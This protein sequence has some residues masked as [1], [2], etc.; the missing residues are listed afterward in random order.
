MM[1]S[2]SLRVN[3]QVRAITTGGGQGSWSR[4]QVKGQVAGEVGGR[5][6]EQVKG[7]RNGRGSREQVKG[8]GQG[9]RSREP[10]KGGRH[11]VPRGT[12]EGMYFQPQ[13]YLTGAYKTDGREPPHQK[14]AAAPLAPLR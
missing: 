4:E 9:S 6:R 3:G 5:S 1:V 13:F 14:A 10:V 12:N 8:A 11:G 2:Q 7:G